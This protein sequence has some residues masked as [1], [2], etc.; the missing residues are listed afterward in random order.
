M[1]RPTD[2]PSGYAAPS[3]AGFP[4]LRN[5]PAR[6]ANVTDPVLVGPSGA[7]GAYRRQAWEQVAGLDE[8]VFAYGEDVDLALRLRAAGWLTA[9]ASEAVAVHIGSASAARRSAWQRRHGGFARGYFLRRY[10]ILASRLGPRAAAT[11]AIVVLG[12]ALIF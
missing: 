10:G 2:R 6:A 1:A 5:L 9:A 3:L 12:D 8:G 7:A 4:R 11:E